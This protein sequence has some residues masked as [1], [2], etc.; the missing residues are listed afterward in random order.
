LPFAHGW[1]AACIHRGA[2]AF[3]AALRVMEGEMVRRAKTGFT[4]IELMIVVAIIAILA[5]V[6]VPQFTKYMRSAKAAEANEMLDLIK[7]G[8][9]SYY[10]TPRVKMGTTTKIHCQFPGY[11]GTTPTGSGCCNIDKNG[12]DR[13][14]PSLSS[15]N[16]ATWSALRFSI[17]DEHYFQYHYNSTGT[18][19]TAMFTAEA[20]AD[21]DCDGLF[22]TFQMVG[23]GDPLATY[24]ECSAIGAPAL[25]RDHETE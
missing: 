15:W 23:S 2:C 3:R 24:H 7:K 11:V 8:S 18:L 6:A 5:V 21:L 1:H 12:D 10:A 9:A 25:F 14:D 20:N 16:A 17:S 4:L 22:S 19:S 13:C